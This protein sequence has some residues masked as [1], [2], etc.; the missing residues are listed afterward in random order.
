MHTSILKKT[1]SIPTV[2]LWLMSP[3]SFAAPADGSPPCVS[4]IE[5]FT[6]CRPTRAE[7]V[8][9]SWDDDAAKPLAVVENGGWVLSNNALIGSVDKRWLTSISLKD[10]RPLW[11]YN[12]PY[13]I[14]SPVAVLGGWVVIGTLN[15]SVTK[16]EFATGKKVWEK[17]VGHFPARAFTL[18]GS[19]LFVYTVNHQLYSL[20]YQSGETNWI[21]DASTSAKLTLRNPAAPIV[22][23]AKIY[24][25]TTDGEIH[26]LDQGSG[27][28][29]WRVNPSY[30]DFRFHDV[31]SDM[32]LLQNRLIVSRYDGVVAAISLDEETH[33]TLWKNTYASLTVAK[34]HEGTLF[35]G[36]INGEVLALEAFSGKEIWRVN[37]GQAVGSITVGEKTIFVAGTHGRIVVLSRASVGHILWTD[38]LES[39]LF[40]EPLV[41]DGKI[42]YT[43]PLKLL[44]GY[45][46]Y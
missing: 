15:G 34:L 46:L 26:A 14:E 2:L 10:R 8:R 22:T 3:A 18:S 23:N 45:K 11:W 6:N 1:L 38:D 36:A 16:I 13:P 17:S 4:S 32:I 41:F 27:K 42:Y 12:T 40:A 39:P 33:R 37:T 44:Y 28:V 19:D 21:Y 35:L 30:I 31:V 5:I 25:G 43:S 20:N 24:L 7:I 9:L 29:L